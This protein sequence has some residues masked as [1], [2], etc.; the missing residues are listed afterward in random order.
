MCGTHWIL[1]AFSGKLL[2]RFHLTFTTNNI[3]KHN[4]TILQGVM[5]H[6]NGFQKSKFHITQRFFSAILSILEGNLKNISF[7]HYSWVFWIQFNIFTV[8][9]LLYC[10]ML[11]L[12]M[13]WQ[14]KPSYSVFGDPPFLL[15]LFGLDLQKH[16]SFSLCFL[17]LP[18]SSRSDFLFSPF[19]LP[20]PLPS[21]SFFYLP[22]FCPSPPPFFKRIIAKK[23]LVPELW[24]SSRVG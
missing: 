14:C 17:L 22:S 21:S 9:K 3:C 1:Q 19:F 20:F 15:L 10:C 23:S 8:Y 18:R 5:A 7:L 4:C 6:I 11:C 16:F 2:G 12:R 24:D 13:Q